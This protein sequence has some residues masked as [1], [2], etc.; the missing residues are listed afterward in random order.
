MNTQ[1]T[2]LLVPRT[3]CGSCGHHV[4]VALSGLQGIENIEIRLSERRVNVRHD[5]D[6]T[7]VASLIEAI[8]EAGYD[9]SQASS[10][11][12]SAEARW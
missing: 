12:G 8:R 1:V 2:R 6:A 7:P 4:R 5:A 11:P 10:D 3:S 9:V